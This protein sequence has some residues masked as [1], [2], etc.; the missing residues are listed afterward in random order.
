MRRFG[1]LEKKSSKPLDKSRR[2]CYHIVTGR[3][4]ERKGGHRNAGLG[5]V[6]GPLLRDG[7]ASAGAGRGGRAGGR[8]GD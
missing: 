6:R 7:R 8:G 2:L 5:S 1:G 4:P 3:N